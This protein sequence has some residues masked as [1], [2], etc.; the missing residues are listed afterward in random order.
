MARVT[1]EDCIDKIPNRFELVLLSSQRAREIGSGAALTVD[2]DRDK[3]SVVSLR[4]IADQTISLDA[5]KEELIK[6]Y[7]KVIEIEEDEDEIIDY[8]EGETEWAAL[9]ENENTDEALADAGM[10]TTEGEAEMQTEENTLDGD[11]LPKAE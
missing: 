7:Q 5:L 9:E 11:D 1:V 4:E 3:N 6:S 8:M 10:H 2:R